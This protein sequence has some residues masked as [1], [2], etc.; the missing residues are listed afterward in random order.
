MIK[1]RYIVFSILEAA[2]TAICFPLLNLIF[3]YDANKCV[4]LLN[5]L[6]WTGIDLLIYFIL[7]FVFR[8]FKRSI[9]QVYYIGVASGFIG[10]MLFCMSRAY[11]IEEYTF[12]SV[13]GFVASILSVVDLV[14]KNDQ[15]NIE[16]I[17]KNKVN[18]NYLNM[19][20]ELSL[21][22]RKKLVLVIEKFIK[23]DYFKLN[24]ASKL[25]GLSD[26]NTSKILKKGMDKKIIESEGNTNTKVFRIVR[27]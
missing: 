26:R 19:I 25:L 1:L 11:S 14:V 6:I 20:G 15:K 17:I 9:K 7:S 10:V 13:F 18:E 27:L 24:D 3:K 22:D 4:L 23:V 8:L 12:L 5:L 21:N 16:Y 2:L